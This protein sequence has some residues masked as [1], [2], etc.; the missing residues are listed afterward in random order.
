M[1]LLLLLVLILTF[2]ESLAE[3]VSS[4]HFL[5]WLTNESKVIHFLLPI[6][7]GAQFRVTC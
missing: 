6:P 3:G 1:N 2:L 7:L 5:S 4:S